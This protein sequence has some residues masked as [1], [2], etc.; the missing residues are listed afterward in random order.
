M[1][2]Y[3][4]ALLLSVLFHGLIPFSHSGFSIQYEEWEKFFIDF[5]QKGESALDSMKNKHQIALEKYLIQLEKEAQ[6]KPPLWSKELK[7][8]KKRERILAYQENY[9]EAHKVKVVADALAKDEEEKTMEARRDGTIARKEISYRQ[10]QEAE[11]Q[12]LTKRIKSQRESNLKKRDFD[13]KRLLQRNRNIQDSL[14]SR[15]VSSSLSFH[16]VSVRLF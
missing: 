13:F 10:R 9:T 5:E 14:K 8:F 12:V 3:A 15:Q 6:S 1:S 4:F 7:E 2:S 16:S 11:I